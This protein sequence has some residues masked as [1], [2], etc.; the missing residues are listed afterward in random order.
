MRGDGMQRILIQ[1]VLGSRAHQS[2]EFVVSGQELIAGRDP[3]AQI[4]FDP[5]RD[6]VVS[7]HHAKIVPEPDGTFQVVDLQSRN[8]TF[9]NNQRVYG[10][11]P[12]HHNDLIQL[13]AGGPEFRFELDPPPLP[14]PVA[15]HVLPEATRQNWVPDPNEARQPVGRATVERMMG[16]VF[17]RVRRDGRRSFWVGFGTVML[18]ALGT[19]ALGMYLYQSRV[20]MQSGL[21]TVQQKSEQVEE[22]LKRVPAAEAAAQ[23]ARQQVERLEAKLKESEQRNSSNQKELMAALEAARK[24]SAA[25]ARMM[26]QQKAQAVPYDIGLANATEKLSKGEFQAALELSTKLTQQDPARWDAYAIAAESAAKLNNIKLA[27]DLYARAV[28]RSSGQVRSFLEEQL[29]A[30]EKAG[31]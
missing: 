1:H 28:A 4:R 2:E 20:Q 18:V 10:A 12:L 8:G 23:E 22:Q 7:R 29:N 19:A 21:T 3:A 27:Q 14:M 11:M 15:G 5:K 13:G 26:E 24:Q 17:T 31:N 16:D 30:L 25:M 9:L 6:D